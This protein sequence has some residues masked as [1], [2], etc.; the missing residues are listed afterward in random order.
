MSAA[1]LL[2]SAILSAPIILWDFKGRYWHRQRFGNR[3]D[4]A[5]TS[6]CAKYFGDEARAIAMRPRQAFWVIIVVSTAARL[7]WAATIKAGN[8]E[9]YHALFPSHFDW[10]YFD[11]PPML[12][13]VAAL[14]LSVS[15]TSFGLRLGFVALSIGSSWLILSRNVG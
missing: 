10:S 12:A 11:H 6:E 13:W 15:G 3:Y 5:E 4:A 9:A 7:I 8:D 1:I 2:I 14:G